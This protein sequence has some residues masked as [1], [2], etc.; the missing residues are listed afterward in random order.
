MENK[1][2]SYTAASAVPMK[3]LLD[4]GLVGT[5]IDRRKIFPRHIQLN[6]TNK[7]TQK[8]FFCSCSKRDQTAQ[9]SYIEIMNIMSQAKKFGCRALTITGG[10]DPL[11]HPR[12][13]DMIKGIWDMGIEIGLVTN[14]DLIYRLKKKSLNKLTWMRISLGDGRKVTQSYWNLFENAVKLGNEV[15]FS[16]SYVVTEKPDFKLIE[17][18]VRFA[19]KFNFVHIRLVNNIFNADK[20]YNAMPSVKKYLKEKKIDDKLVIYQDRGH[21]TKGTKNCLISL[22]KPVIGA[23]G[24]WYACC[25]SQYALKKPA[26]DYDPAT[27]ISK[28]K[29]VNGLIDIYKN[30]KP[31]DGRICWKCYYK[32]YNDVLGAL[33]SDIK[34]EVFI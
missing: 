17:K 20:L 26:M 31:F 16:F 15:D 12:I 19:N 2:I 25:G 14:A 6:P 33:L 28:K 34:H 22:L 32:N 1:Q 7:C 11:C 18:M 13:N 5:M 21:W 3:I 4:R 30:Q 10:G 24:Y 8:C 9:L 27:K 23:D 29:G